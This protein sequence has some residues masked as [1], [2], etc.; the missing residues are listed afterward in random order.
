MVFPCNEIKKTAWDVLKNF[1]HALI[2]REDDPLL[3]AILEVYD[4]QGIRNGHPQNEMK[5]ELSRPSLPP[6]IRMPASL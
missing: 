3:P 1:D 4:K 5:G 2:L 6:P